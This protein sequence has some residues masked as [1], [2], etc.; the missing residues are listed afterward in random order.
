MPSDSEVIITDEFG[1]SGSANQHTVRHKV[2]V[3]VAA[4]RHLLKKKSVCQRIP[5]TMV[6]I[7]FALGA[8]LF[9]LILLCIVH[10]TWFTPVSQ[11][12]LT[13]IFLC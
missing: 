13:L 5:R 10:E 6:Q 7:V 3:P 2:I 12:G 9:F 1:D 8:I 11:T 4:A